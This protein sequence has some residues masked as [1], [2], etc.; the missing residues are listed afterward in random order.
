MK[1]FIA[2]IL[3]VL[4]MLCLCACGGYKM[5]DMERASF[6][7]FVNSVKDPT[8]LILYGDIVVC[9]TDKGMTMQ[10][11][12]NAKNGFGAY[13]G[14]T[15]GEV[16]NTGGNP[17][18]VDEDSQYFVDINEFLEPSYAERIENSGFNLYTISGEDVANSFG[19]Q[20][21]PLS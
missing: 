1:R 16:H 18:F 12:Y 17:L 15:A 3:I 10:F 21:M 19:I 8:S 2:I 13:V 9:Q 7:C 11:N 20:W 4:S 6:Q 14:I 5:T